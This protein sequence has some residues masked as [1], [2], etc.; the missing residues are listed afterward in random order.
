MR[1]VLLEVLHVSKQGGARAAQHSPGDG[2]HAVHDQSR[3]LMGF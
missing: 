1:H 3:Q 2:V